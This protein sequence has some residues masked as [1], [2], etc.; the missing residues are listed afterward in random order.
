MTFGERLAS[1]PTMHEPAA[2]LASS[3]AT[4]GA[5]GTKGYRGI[6]ACHC[7]RIISCYWSVSSYFFWPWRS[8]KL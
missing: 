5:M 4:L 2:L 3:N 8:G 7:C 6:C 1:R